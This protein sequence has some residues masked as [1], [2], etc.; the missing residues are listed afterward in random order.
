MGQ[1][2]DRETGHGQNRLILW[3]I[4]LLPFK[5]HLVNEEQD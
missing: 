5:T 3:E 1:D 2:E 4:N